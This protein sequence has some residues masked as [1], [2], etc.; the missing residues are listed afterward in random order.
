MERERERAQTVITAEH[1]VVV[2]D[3]WQR[4]GEAFQFDVASH[5]ST[6]PPKNT[7]QLARN[8]IFANSM[9]NEASAGAD[10]GARACQKRRPSH[11]SWLQVAMN[12]ME[13]V[14]SRF[15]EAISFHHFRQF[16]PYFVGTVVGATAAYAVVTAF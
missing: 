12:S 8:L 15:M 13:F 10:A 9:A 7:A 2:V 14:P 3:E 5:F 16:L 4:L 11:L 6:A 1:I